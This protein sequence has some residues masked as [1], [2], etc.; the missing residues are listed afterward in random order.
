[1][2]S[3][4]AAEGCRVRVDIQSAN[5]V[6]TIGGWSCQAIRQDLPQAVE[7][8][9]KP[10]VQLVAVDGLNPTDPFGPIQPAPVPELLTD[11]QTFISP[12][13]PGSSLAHHRPSK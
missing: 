9:S 11:T 2:A 5:C 10:H 8:P 6:R 1:M 4:S 12:V 13:P 7:M 3:S